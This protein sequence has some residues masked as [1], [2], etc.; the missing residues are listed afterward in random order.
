[1]L[2]RFCWFNL[3]HY[4]NHSPKI[5]ISLYIAFF[6]V[7]KSL[8]IPDVV[9]NLTFN[10]RIKTSILG[11]SLYKDQHVH[12]TCN[13]GQMDMDDTLAIPIQLSQYHRQFPHPTT[14][15]TGTAGNSF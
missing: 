10:G 1:M 5:Y 9:R 15:N 2:R 3:G 12:N 6:Y 13:S 14:L 7:R 11:Y 8:Q 4:A